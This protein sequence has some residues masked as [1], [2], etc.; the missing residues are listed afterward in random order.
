MMRSF[1]A[2]ECTYEVEA[3]WVDHTRYVYRAGELLA[4]CEP[5]SS[6][7]DGP[8]LIQKA[9]DRFR[10]SMPGYEL[11]ER[12]SIDRPTEGAELF[13]QRFGGPRAL[14]EISVFWRVGDV[15]WVF[16]V[17]GPPAEHERGMRA[18]ESF[19]ESY[20]PVEAA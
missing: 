8:A 9:L 3:D 6:A 2:T 7:A 5:F 20:E 1:Q 13:S 19:L 14:F 11:A 15:M 18:V 16:R 17:Q 12:R 10:V 4:L